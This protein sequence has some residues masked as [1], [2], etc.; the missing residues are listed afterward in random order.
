MEEKRGERG[1]KRGE[2]GEEPGRREEELLTAIE[3]G[4]ILVFFGASKT[5]QQKAAR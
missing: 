2:R 4:A 5:A 1:E 3:L